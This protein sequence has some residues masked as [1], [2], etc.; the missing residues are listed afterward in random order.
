[1]RCMTKALQGRRVLVT[2]ASSGIGRATAEAC[3]AAGAD[4]AVLARRQERLAQLADRYGAVP[5]TGDVSRTEAAPDL[6]AQAV[7]GLGGLDVLVNSA[8]IARPGL[9]ADADPADWKAMFDVNVLGLLA[10]TQAAIPHLQASDGGASIVNVSSMSGR[11]VPAPTGGTYAATKFAVHAISESLRQEL[12]PAGIRVTTIAPG[13]V[14]T[15]IFDDL[16]PSDLSDRYRRM[17]AKVGI[18]PDDVAAAIVHAVAAPDSVTTVE[19][20]IV[21][22]RQTDAAYASSVSED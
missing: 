9:I 6:I 3:L 13:F 17:T 4:V 2:G 12:Q 21:P 19:I 1:M 14:D 15:E 8:G 22:T 16:E 10:L 11:R 20:A 7:D 18:T 5:I